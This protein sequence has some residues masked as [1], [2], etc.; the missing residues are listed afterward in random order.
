MLQLPHTVWSL[1]LH[2]EQTSQQLTFSILP[3]SLNFIVLDSTL[4]RKN[5]NHK[6]INMNKIHFFLILSSLVKQLTQHMTSFYIIIFHKCTIIFF[7]D[8]RKLNITFNLITFN[9]I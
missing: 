1:E 3:I 7:Y 4:N 9:S 6:E 8:D 5:N 2:T